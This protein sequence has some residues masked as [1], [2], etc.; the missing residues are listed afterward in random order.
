MTPGRSATPKDNQMENETMPKK[1]KRAAP[2][3][4][5]PELTVPI[6]LWVDPKLYEALQKIAAEEERTIPQVIRRAVR[7]ALKLT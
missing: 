2:P 1:A 7:A 4:K 6:K 5:P 3:R